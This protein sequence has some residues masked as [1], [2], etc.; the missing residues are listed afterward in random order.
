MRERRESPLCNGISTTTSS[1]KIALVEV[2]L[3]ITPSRRGSSP[4]SPLL[5]IAPSL[6]IA[7]AIV[8]CASVEIAPIDIAEQAKR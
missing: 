6:F 4:P 8:V 5:L 7:I 1:P 2:S 3:V